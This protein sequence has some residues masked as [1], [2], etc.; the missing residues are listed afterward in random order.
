MSATPILDLIETPPK[1]PQTKR[2]VLVIAGL[3]G[4]LLGMAPIMYPRYFAGFN[5][6]LFLPALYVTVAVHEVGH[7]LAGRI[8]GMRPGAV[9]IG[10]I[11]I[12]KSG[13]RW[14]IRFDYRRMFSGGLAKVLPEK[15]DFRPASFR[16][17]VAGG[18]LASI[19]FTAVCGL[20]ELRYGP[21]LWGTTATLFWMGLLTAVGPLVPASRGLNKS[22]GAR[23][24]ILARRPEQAR[25]WMALYALQ[26]EETNGVRPRD[27][28][29]ELVAQMLLAEPSSGEYPYIQ[30]LAFYRQMDQRKEQVA[31]EHLEKALATSGNITKVFRQCIFL[32]AASSSALSRGNV[33]Q[34][35]TWVERAG[36]VK[37]PVSTDNAEAVI[38]IREGRHED[39]V[40]F[41]AAARARIERLKLDSGLARFAQ[42]QL[43][44]YAEICKSV[45]TDVQV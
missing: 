26:T 30:L 44:E 7:L 38:A 9:V 27:W 10:G 40:R 11:S 12:F 6:F 23:L 14:L 31:L 32:E 15:G 42:E 43:A 25:A 35:R 39:A 24:W 20:M 22:D 37:E 4:V 41:L 36:K 13:Q 33:S 5:G 2:L 34:A 45:T 1:P 21:G 17:M 8:V 16:W 18:P 3:V 28:D 19:L 29:A